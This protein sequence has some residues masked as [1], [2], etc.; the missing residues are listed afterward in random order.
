MKR[1]PTTQDISWFLDQHRNKQLDLNPPYQRRS[2]WTRKDRIFFLDTIFHG[3]PSPAVFLHKTI[4]DRGVTTYHVVDG[5]QRLETILQF[6]DNKLRIAAD[7]GNAR[8]DGKSWSDLAADERK[9]FW[10][11]QIPVEMVDFEDESLVREVFDRLNRNARR[12]TRQEL[13]HAR[14]EGWF[15]RTVDTE[16]AQPE[17]LSVGLTTAA[18]E[19]RLALHQTLSEFLLVV[20]E[21]KVLG[22]D[23]DALDAFY[24]QYDDFDDE[25]QERRMTQAEFNTAFRDAKDRLMQ[26]EAVN[27][28]VSRHA[29]AI[30]N[31]Y[32]IWCAVA[33]HG[34]EIAQ[35]PDAAVR[36]DDF[37]GNVGAVA[38][39]AATDATL[40][41]LNTPQYAHAITYWQHLRGANTD[42]GPREQRLAALMSALRGSET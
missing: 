10:N 41:R 19:K 2:V 29:S 15:A 39:E 8:L 33:L 7:F 35:I 21:G 17:W 1:H 3:F 11:Y 26:I 20:L 22:F 24:A 34:A 32:T 25:D 28:A 31:I 18:R 37:M 36:Y 23:Q 40:A 6:V 38:T 9:S 5:K 14:F 27:Q 42:L 4:D 13:R 16:S 30:A 12:L